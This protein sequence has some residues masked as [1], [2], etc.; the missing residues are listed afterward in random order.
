MNESVLLD[1]RDIRAGPQNLQIGVGE[2]SSKTVDDVPFVCD[3]G[4]GAYP[5]DN[6]GNAI[7]AD[8]IVP[9]CHDIMSSDR[10]FS[11]LDGDER[12]GS[13][14]DWENT[15][16]KKD[17]LLGEHDGSLELWNLASTGGLGLP[18]SKRVPYLNHL[19]HLVIL[20]T[21]C[22]DANPLATDGVIQHM[23]PP[24]E[25][26]PMRFPLRISEMSSVTGR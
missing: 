14:D 19:D 11:L 18:P 4:L 2:G 21:W 23:G 10:I 26:L 6:G 9:E 12:G 15:E 8:N 7:G 13:S 24:N 25:D 20:W 22:A 17:E 3:L 5:V 16:D 1:G